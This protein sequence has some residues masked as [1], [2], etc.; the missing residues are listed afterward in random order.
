[1]DVTSLAD[2]GNLIRL[3]D[4]N[5]ATRR[6]HLDDAVYPFRAVWADDLIFPEGE[7]G[8]TVYGA[9]A[10]RA[11]RVSRNAQPETRRAAKA[12]QC[13]GRL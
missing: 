7:P 10:Q 1:M 12:Q 2:Q 3:V 9:A 6:P 5:D 13:Q 4:G 11:P 8:V